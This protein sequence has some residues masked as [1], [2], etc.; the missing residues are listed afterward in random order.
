MSVNTISSPGP[1]AS[2][3]SQSR[4]P[5]RQR[6]LVVEDDVDIRRLNTEILI[7]AG[8]LVNAAKD[9]KTA[10]EALHLDS[11]DLMITDNNMPE[12]TGVELLKMLHV[13]GLAVPV[14]MATGT[15]PTWELAIF[16]WLQPVAVLLKPYTGAEL[17]GS[18][19]AILQKTNYYREA[20]AHPNS[21]NRPPADGLQP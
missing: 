20:K 8:Y 6:I 15:L 17:L 1:S 5:P 7:R 19:N 9:G 12:L 18:V 10:W 2:N 21:Q 16:P 13:A 14:I 4:P 3:L 11:Y